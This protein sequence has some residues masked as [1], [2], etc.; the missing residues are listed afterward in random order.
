MV[1]KIRADPDI[2]EEDII[3]IDEKEEEKDATPEEI[4]KNIQENLQLFKEL[5][6]QVDSPENIHNRMIIASNLG[7]LYHKRGN[8]GEARKFFLLALAEAQKVQDEIQSAS[9]RGT[10]GSLDLETGDY[11]SAQKHYE[12]AYQ[13][14]QKTTHLNERI[15][16][17]QNLGIIYLKLEHQEEKAVNCVL[18]AMQMA[19]KL[20]DEIQFAQSI[21][22]LLEFYE[23]QRKFDVLKELK[24]KALQ[25]WEVMKLTN[26]QFKTLID[27]GVL[28]QILENHTEA[29]QY[30]KKAFNIAYHDNALENMYHA[31]GFIGESYFKLRDLE[32]AKKAYLDAFMIAVYLGLTDEIEKMKTVLIA[33]GYS[34]EFIHQKEHEAL[35]SRAEEQ[36]I[37]K[38]QSNQ[39][40]LKSIGKK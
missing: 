31:Q 19:I 4:D 5:Y 24:L 1:K 8:F 22:I 38:N 7:M 9:L 12:A 33:L 14:W 35:Q 26:R 28:S 25:F 29:I 10:L 27:L 40:N 17:L 13:Y 18:E 20:E 37:K 2:S 23:Q 39:K 6:G 30:F 32:K 15:V 3:D 21:Q 34:Y 16:C 36:K 11:R